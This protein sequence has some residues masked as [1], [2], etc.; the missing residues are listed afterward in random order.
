[1]VKARWRARILDHLGHYS[2]DLMTSHAAPWLDHPEILAIVASACAVTEAS[3]PER[4][5]MPGIY[6]SLATLLGLHDAD[7][8]GPAYVKWEMGLLQALGYG[9]DLS[10]CAATGTADDLTYVSPRTG[11]AVSTE[12]GA[13]YHEKLFP[14][15]GF[16]L[17]VGG[18]DDADISDGLDLT[19]H[20][21]SRHVFAHPHS[22]LLIAQAGDLPL[23]RQR[24]GDFYRKAV[25]KAE[26]VVA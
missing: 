15:P 23:A 26:V 21:L 9:M 25:E 6:A 13:P 11:R 5:P 3:L 20:F 22:R 12:A 16:L 24:L 18:W 17:G 19:G 7:L 1:R 8:W 4:Q 14:L 2:L 10:Q